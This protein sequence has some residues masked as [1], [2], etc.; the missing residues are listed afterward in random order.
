VMQDQRNTIDSYEQFL[1]TKAQNG[2]F[3]GFEPIWM[4]EFLFPFQQHLVDWAIR[5]GKAAILADC[6]LGKTP[7]HLVWAENVVQKTN[8]PVL[9][10]TPLA[11]GQQTIREAE[12]FGIEA[13]RS[14]DGKIPGKIVVTNYEQLHKFNP[15]EF[16]GAVCDESSAIKGDGKRRAEVT[17]FLRTLPYRLLCTA[18]AAPND[19]VELGTS[20]EALGV[21]GQM[22]MLNRFFVNNRNTSDTRGHWR[23]F[24]APHEYHLPQW[25]FKGHAE[26]PFFRWV[27]GWARPCRKPSDLGFEDIIRLASG[28]TVRFK[29][30]PLVE[31]VHVVS[32]RTLR[33][34]DLFPLPAKNRN[35]ELEECRRTLPE[36]CEMAAE[37]VANTGK[38]FVIWCQLNPEGDRLE[39]L[40]PD[41]LQVSGSDSDEA[42][43]EAYEAFAKGQSRGLIS[44]QK[45]GGWGLNWQHC[46]HVLEFASHSWEAHYQGVRRCWRFGQKETVVNDLIATE[47]QRGIQENLKRKADQADRMF[48]LLVTNM[49][50]SQKVEPIRADA[51]VEVPAWL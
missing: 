51:F 18:T 10:M 35:E 38:P 5:K 8:R 50:Q 2:E 24:A 23:G 13:A 19:Y 27:C 36:R 12:K 31:N 20:S 37:L 6:G 39:K 29:L 22:D 26:T 11:V 7:M 32:T 40:I 17:E 43:E 30:P 44:K 33:D 21:M 15:S 47:G 34:G 45:I 28:D 1:K 25:R 9:V 42:K 41:A 16:V 48:S 46:P 3:S 14:R 49:N 4:P